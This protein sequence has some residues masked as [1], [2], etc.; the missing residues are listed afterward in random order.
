MSEIPAPVPSVIFRPATPEDVPAIMAIEFSSFVHAGERFGR[1]R[2][3]YLVTSDR[4]VAT[5][6]EVEGRVLGW[7]VGF[8]W[9]RT[10]E[11]WG[12]IYA[13]A[14]HPHSRGQ[15]LGER[16]LHH[17][18]AMLR[19]GGAK[20]IFL[21][22]R[23][24]NQAAVKLYKKAGFTRCRTLPNYYAPGVDGERMVNP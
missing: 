18:I 12:R 13:L 15:R 3:A 16:L 11:P 9:R 6:A 1:R 22:V 23:P 8:T 17:M 5:V 24:D 4:C 21:E 7:V 2:V 20:R 19:A 14:V 10:P